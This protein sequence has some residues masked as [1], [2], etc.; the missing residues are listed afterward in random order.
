MKR[1]AGFAIAGGIWAGF[2]GLSTVSSHA[3]PLVPPIEIPPIT[4]A[5]QSTES[6]RVNE[7]EEH[8]RRLSGQV[9]ELNFLLLQMQE[10]LRQLE[11][12]NELRFLELEDKRSEVDSDT[13]KVARNDGGETERLEKPKT[14]GPTPNPDEKSLLENKSTTVD[15][16][17]PESRALGTLTF[18]Q[19]G[20]VVDSQA[21]TSDKLAG[22]PGVFGDGVDGSVEAAEFGTTPQEVLQ[23]GL[24]ELRARQFERAQQAFSAYLKAWPNDPDAGQA[25]YYLGESHFWQKDY[26]RAA[27]SY[28][29]AHNN[30]PEAKTAPDNLLALGLALAGLNQREVACA[31]YAEVLRQYPE[32]EPRLGKRV[33]DEQAATR[34]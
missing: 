19:D 7:L 32:S 3:R 12:N 25:K 5:I 29:E 26:Y 28:L 15:K 18:D 13:N 14:S 8:V 24:G 11:E 6:Y 31:T 34:C 2:V 21:N 9:E 17:G 23:A 22:L 16:R 10:K 4:H 30:Y 1:L 20:N 33:R 27:D